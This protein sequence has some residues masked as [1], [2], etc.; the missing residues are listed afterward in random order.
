MADPD[1]GSALIAYL[2][3]HLDEPRLGFAEPPVG[4]SGGFDSRIVAFR[5]RGAPPAYAGPLILRLLG[6]H[7]D[8][9][10][11]LREAVIQN[12][13]AG[14]GYPA[15]R[16]LLATVDPTPLGGPFMI[17]ERLP[18]KPL[19]EAGLFRIGP[20]LLEVQ[21]RLHALDADV[22]LQELTREE[23]ASTA[24]GGPPLN[25]DAMTVGG[26][27]AQLEQRVAGGPLDG[28]VA[29][30]RWLREHRP[31]EPRR[32]V[33]CHGDFHP[34]N[35]LVSGTTVTAVLDWPNALVADAAFDVAATRTILG[36]TPVEL[37]RLP[38]PVRWLARAWRPRMAER[39]VRGYRRQRDLDPAALAYYESLSCMRHLVRVVENRRR[40]GPLNPLDASSFGGA[41]AARFARLTGIRPSLPPLP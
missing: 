6:R 5:L 8:R 30:V 31:P 38:A 3:E 12:T 27:L 20:V 35:I 9:S 33:I 17:M 39:Y 14:M 13:L 1:L 7:H 32:R 36:L 40:G 4:L 10:R 2:Q 25:R 18:G 37:L 22:L 34:F 23:R 29:G 16:S 15:P 21:L 11:V 24:A 26:H 28:L 41:L 19:T